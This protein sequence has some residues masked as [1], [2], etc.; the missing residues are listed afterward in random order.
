MSSI[1]LSKALRTKA[2]A[3]RRAVDDQ[4][5][6][7]VRTVTVGDQDCPEIE[8]DA[9]GPDLFWK[10]VTILAIVLA[11][12]TTIGIALYGSYWLTAYWLVWNSC[13]TQGYYC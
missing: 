11:V 12:H 10:I 1:S 9:I 13:W 6:R 5:N 3:P 4:N 8:N 2:A 7:R